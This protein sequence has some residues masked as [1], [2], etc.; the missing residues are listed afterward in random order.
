MNMDIKDYLQKWLIKANND[1]IVA[2]HELQFE[3][4]VTDI[5]CFHCQQSV[6]KFLKAFLIFNNRD[7]EKTHNISFLIQSCAE[8]DKSFETVD[9]KNLNFFGVSVRY[10]DDFYIPSLAETEYYFSIAENIKTLVESKIKY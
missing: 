3:D 5:I 8:I 10:P 4:P 9:L 6:E 1:L 7:F 2:S